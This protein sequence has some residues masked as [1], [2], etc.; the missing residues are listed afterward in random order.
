MA[1]R[2]K[3]SESPGRAVRR[4]CRE[5]V[6]KA[7]AGLRQNG[8]PAAVHGARK[9]IKK[10]RAALEL[11]CGGPTNKAGRRA[12]KSLRKAAKCL[13]A[14]RDAR[15]MLRAFENL[16][17]D[18][19]GRFPQL[20]DALS[21]H[22]RRELRGKEANQAVKK[23]GHFLRKARSRLKDFKIHADGWAAIGPGLKRTLSLGRKSFV[24]VLA[25]PDSDSLHEWRKHVKE[26][27][28]QMALLS[29]A[30]SRATGRLLDD[31]E[32]LGRQLGEE[33]DLSLLKEFVGRRDDAR[34][35]CAIGRLIGARQKVLR[36]SVVKL[37]KR[38]FGGQLAVLL[39]RLEREWK[40]WQRRCC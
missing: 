29:P 6:G 35:R 14:S 13:A 8:C 22:A 26:L 30:W 19:T 39:A 31:L 21:E 20:H 38:F 25:R 17:A 18:V 36:A 23:A 15:V 37:G 5:R 12:G 16:A 3:K 24:A 11:V 34:E 2:F 28:Y 10:V 40:A 9:E 4:V 32:I 33:H 7:S 27:W 1:F